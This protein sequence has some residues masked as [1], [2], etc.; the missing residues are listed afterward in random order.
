M[1]IAE[2]HRQ[3][4]AVELADKLMDSGSPTLRMLSLHGSAEDA[5]IMELLHACRVAREEVRRENAAKEE[6]P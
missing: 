3:K 6:T 4:A 1:T 5:A 2:E